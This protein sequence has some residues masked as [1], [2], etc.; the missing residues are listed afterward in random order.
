MKIRIDPDIK[1]LIPPPSAQELDGLER[2]LVRDGCRDPLVLW[3]Q[4]VG[5]AVLLDG[6]N[7]YQIC[8]KHGL[9]FSTVVL[10]L[11]SRAHAMIWVCEN[12]LHRRNLNETQRAMMGDRIATRR[13]GARTD[14]SPIGEMSQA[15]AAKLMNVGE[16]SIQRA[17]VVRQH[18]SPKLIEASRGGLIPVSLGEVIAELPHGDQDR[19]ADQ[20]LARGDAQPAR[21][22]AS[23]MRRQAKSKKRVATHTPGTDEGRQSTGDLGETVLAAFRSSLRIQML[24]TAAMKVGRLTPERRKELADKCRRVAGQFVDAADYLEGNPKGGDMVPV[25]DA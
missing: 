8:A 17:G 23:K 6:H 24:A 7:R 1:A 4:E 18:G 12:Q 16:R 14:L 15:Q 3:R 20:C 9:P 22:A 11:P 13:Q 25:V 5:D 2:D 21:I 19:I 10:D